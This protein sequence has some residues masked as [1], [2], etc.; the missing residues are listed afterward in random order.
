[1]L[2]YEP[3]KADSKVKSLWRRNGALKFEHF[4]DFQPDQQKTEYREWFDS[5]FD[6]Y[7]G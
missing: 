7:Y 2:A 1:M 6:R 3:P 4:P 5:R